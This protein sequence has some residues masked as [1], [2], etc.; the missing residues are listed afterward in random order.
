MLTL[1][2]DARK[3]KRGLWENFVDFKVVKT[4]NGS[5][6]MVALAESCRQIVH[7]H[8]R[9]L[10]TFVANMHTIFQTTYEKCS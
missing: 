7:M 6:Y 8:R 4:A 5:A 1:Q 10:S 2:S 9:S 3:N